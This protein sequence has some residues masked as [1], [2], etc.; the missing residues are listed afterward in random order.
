ML[1]LEFAQAS[2]PGRT[3]DHN[4]D[5]LGYFVPRSPAPLQTQGWLFVLADGVGGQDRGEVASRTAVES[6]IAGFRG[7]PDGESYFNLLPRLVKAAN[8]KVFETGMATGPGGSS[9]ATTV[10]TCAFRYDRVVVCHVGDSRCYLIRHR[11]A[12][13]LTR[14]HTVTNEQV[15]MGLLSSREAAES[16]TRHLLSRSLGNAMFVNV[17]T[18]DHQVLPGDV[19]LLCSDGLHG[20]VTAE[21]M[22]DAVAAHNNLEEA[23]RQLVDVANQKDGSDNISVQLIRIRSVER[24]GMYRGRPYKLA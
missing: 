18:R 19:L 6:L 10:V 1:D 11:H 21:E 4:E 5:Y 15:R 23:V 17:D 22:A 16:E 13:A 9:M 7:A 12:E 8:T 14:D 3:R 20:A 24:V 2:D